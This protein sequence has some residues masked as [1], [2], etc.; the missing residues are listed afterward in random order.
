[1]LMAALVVVVIASLVASVWYWRT[2]RVVPP[3]EEPRIVSA[4]FTSAGHRRVE[5]AHEIEKV[6]QQA[7]RDHMAAGRDI[8]DAETLRTAM[9]AARQR[10]LDRR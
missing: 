7:V 5:T 4:V 2:S 8:N 1:M 10:I 3:A 9:L 6:M